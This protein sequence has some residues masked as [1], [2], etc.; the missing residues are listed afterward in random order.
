[1]GRIRDQSFVE[2]HIIAALSILWHRSTNPFAAEWYAVVWIS[3]APINCIRDVKS[4]DSN[5]LPWS[6]VIVS[7]EPKRAT[8]L[9]EKARQIVSASISRS[10]MASDHL[11]K[12]SMIVKQDR[13]PSE[14]GKGPTISMWIC[15][16]RF[17]GAMKLDGFS[18]VWRD[19]LDAWQSRQDLHSRAISLCRFGQTY[20]FYIIRS[21]TFA[22]GCAG[23]WNRLKIWFLR[24]AGI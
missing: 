17:S 8:Q 13:Y 4:R 7:G 3:F 23:W 6:V 18:I 21:V 14:G 10:E 22:P 16:K 12:R 19:I 2:W 20:R 5:W 15:W 1:M 9:S 11:E 24:V